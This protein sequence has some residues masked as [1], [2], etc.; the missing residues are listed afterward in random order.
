[1]TDNII[2]T[3]RKT[4]KD[5]FHQIIEHKKENDIRKT[6]KSS[7]WLGTGTKMWQVKP[8]NGILILSFL[9]I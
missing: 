2:A 1:M 5:L 3:E 7:S 6:W 8:V 4:N 9:I